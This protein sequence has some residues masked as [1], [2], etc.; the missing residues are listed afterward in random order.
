MGELQKLVAVQGEKIVEL[1][2]H[3]HDMEEYNSDF[4][5]KTTLGEIIKQL[6]E[7][8]GFPAVP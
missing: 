8:A 3:V 4:R 5:E 2:K 7:A 6:R 1:Q